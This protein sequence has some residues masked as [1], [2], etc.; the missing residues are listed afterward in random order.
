MDKLSREVAMALAASMSYGKWKAMQP[1]VKP[2]PKI[3]EGTIACPYCGE[4]FI[5]RHHSSKYCSPYCQRY[6]WERRTGYKQK[7]QSAKD[8]GK[9]IGND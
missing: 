6:D 9:V 4:L 7:E 8:E 1:I 2:Q 3:P 5:P